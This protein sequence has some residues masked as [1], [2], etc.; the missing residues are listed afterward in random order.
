MARYPDLKSYIQANYEELLISEVQKFVNKSYDGN[1]FHSI[2]VLSLCKNVIDNLIVETLSCHDDIGPRIKVDI[3]VSADIVELGLGTKRYEVDRRTRW[4]II[5]IQA[6]ILD[7]LEDIIVLGIEEFYN[8]HWEKENALD[9]FFVPYIYTADLED[10][11]DDF[12]LF[13]CSDAIYDGYKLP[14]Y[15]ILQALELEYYI[16]D[17][18]EH[19]FGR[20]YFK[21]STATVYQKY[22]NM[23]EIRIEDQ[24]INPGTILIS[25]Q[26]YFLGSDGTQRL[27]IAHEIIHWYLHQKYFKLLALLDDDADMMSCEVEPNHY[28]EN[29]M[30]GQKAHW[31]AEWQANA[32][33]I[34]IAMP[35]ELVE[36]AFQE[37]KAAANPYRFKGELVEDILRRVAVLFDVPIFV[38]KQR[39]RQL[40]F[41]HSDGAFVYVDG[42]YHEPFWFTEGILEQHQTF[43]IDHD[44]FNQ[45]YSK[46]ADFADLI[47]SG[48]FLY[49]GYVVCI[50]DPKYVT[51]EFHYEE[52]QLALTDYAREHA[53]ECCLVFSW[54][55]T[56]YL[57]DEYEFYGQ[58]YLSKE[59]NAEYY[60]EH[61]YDKNFNSKCVQTADSIREAVVA[62]NAAYDAEKQVVIDM[63]SKGCDNFSDALIYHMDRKKVTVDELVERSGL[64][65]TTIKK[66]RA[67]KVL[68]PPIQNIMA[69][70][71]GLN[72]P[73][74]LAL[75]MLSK[76]SYQLGESPRD[77]AYKFLLDYSDGTLQ[78]WNSILDAFNQP[79]IPD[80][81]NQ[82]TN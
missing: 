49:L 47:D 77:R 14:V 56:S 22:P 29:M 71:I 35:R 2:N 76:A 19:C 67:G 62:Y 69:I 24:K 1:G 55:S 43:V 54:H 57:K 53:D 63:M 58:A 72:L 40:G 51:V 64:S 70:C 44:G 12:T 38:A 13:Y 45:V 11:A 7:G 8:R 66:Y 73:K 37:A 41:D 15:D 36:K 28:D 52:V 80:I 16:A 32:L 30:L 75:N 33:A 26:K 65:D 10:Q 82:K 59:V 39:T 50:N 17:L 27:T 81:R 60:V 18:P 31:F 68:Q 3:I 42:K 23:E 74:T 6:N 25:R 9:Q 21:E 4:F 79:N 34:R 48:R 5:H 20:V 78:Q 46:S 61:T